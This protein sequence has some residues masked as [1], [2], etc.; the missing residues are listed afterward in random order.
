MATVTG[1]INET[2]P[3]NIAPLEADHFPR[4]STAQLHL[5]L[6]SPR[7]PSRPPTRNAP[8]PPGGEDM[9]KLP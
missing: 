2:G 1:V 7:Y 8:R 6:Q 4:P 5:L 3:R 9:E